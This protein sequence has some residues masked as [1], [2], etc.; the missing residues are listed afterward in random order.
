MRAAAASSA[1][2]VLDAVAAF[3]TLREL[4][5]VLKG[6]AAT[7]KRSELE[8]QARTRFGSFRAHFANV[9]STCDSAL[10]LTIRLLV[11]RK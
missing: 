8:K 2:R 5:N 9:A 4:R 3:R 1:R 6:H 7:Q 11:P 10:E